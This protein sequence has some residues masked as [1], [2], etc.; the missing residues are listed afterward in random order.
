[1][2][3]ALG[4]T[5]FVSLFKVSLY[6]IIE[7][8]RWCLIGSTAFPIRSYHTATTL[9][10]SLRHRNIPITFSTFQLSSLRTLFPS[11]TRPSELLVAFFPHLN[12]RQRFFS[13]SPLSLTRDECRLR[14]KQLEALRDDRALRIGLLAAASHDLEKEMASTHSRS[15]LSLHVSLLQTTLSLDGTVADMSNQDLTVNWLDEISNSNRVHSDEMLPLR[16][17]SRLVQ[18]WPRFFLIPPAAYIIFRY[19]YRPRASIAQHAKEAWETTRMFWESWVLQP[20]KGILATVRTGGDEGIRVISKEAL[21][22]DLDV[23]SAYSARID[24]TKGSKS[25]ERMAVALG[26][27]QLGYT[28]Q[29]IDAL[30]HQVERGDLTA[31]LK[32]YEEDIKSPIRSALTGTLVRSLLI[33]VQKMKVSILCLPFQWNT[34]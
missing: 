11:T 5:H 34:R 12:S 10:S 23:S 20:I 21:R 30:H 1:M 18:I 33:Q 28:Q 7:S 13:N 8:L 19:V 29:Q 3:N 24:G 27:D 6:E 31:V 15:Q 25:L 9:V 14:R 26:K 16:R 4:T 22:A 17:P 32:V 2:L